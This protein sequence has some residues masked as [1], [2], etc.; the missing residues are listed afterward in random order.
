MNKY[1][2]IFKI[3]FQEEFAYRLNFILW[4]FRNVLQILIF[5]FLWDAAFS[6]NATEIFGYDKAKIFTY[7]FVL[8]IVRAIVMSS[9]ST[10]V[11]GQIANGEL[12]NLLLKPV[13]FFKYWITRDVSS[14]SLNILFGAFETVI[15]VLILKPNLYFQGNP[16]YFLAFILSLFIGMFIFF[17]LMML[18]NMISF[19]VPELAWGAQFLMIVVVADFLSGS[20]FPIDVFPNIIYQII[21]FTP[22]PYLIF[23]PI[24]IYLGNFDLLL[25]IQS[26][27]IGLIWC[28][29]LWKITLSVWKKGLL[30]Y[31]VTGR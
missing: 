5:F 13:N 17:N 25:T 31:D 14:K 24:K 8:I 30:A 7:A 21:R 1:L 6:G 11:G 9:R 4:R 29:L 12:T 16:Y 10:D 18:T 23:I 15:L 22:F 3:S 20:F 19:W 26:L 27:L 28:A 2:S